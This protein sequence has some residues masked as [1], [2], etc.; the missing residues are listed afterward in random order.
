MDY[1]D[2]AIIVNVVL[3]LITLLTKDQETVNILFE[4]KKI[5][6]YIFS[7]LK[8]RDDDPEGAKNASLV[9]GIPTS[10]ATI[11]KNPSI[12]GSNSNKGTKARISHPTTIK[13]ATIALSRLASKFDAQNIRSNLYIEQL[14]DFDNFEFIIKY[15]T[16]VNSAEKLAKL[17]G[18]DPKNI[19]L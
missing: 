19:I 11:L 16:S 13:L 15:I 2:D 5:I 7:R 14:K 3:Q 17:A 8:M 4:N 18:V 10:M 9:P 12:M 6:N 1:F